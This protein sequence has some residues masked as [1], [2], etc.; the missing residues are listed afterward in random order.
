V[1]PH[2]ERLTTALADRYRIERELGQ[3]GMA[4]DRDHL[5]TRL[6]LGR[7]QQAVAAARQSGI[8]DDSIAIAAT[9]YFGTPRD[10]ALGAAQRQARLALSPAATTVAGRRA[11]YTAACQMGQWTLVH[12]P[13]GSAVEFISVLRR[14][15]RTLDAV[16]APEA[17]PVCLAMLEAMQAVRDRRPDRVALVVQ[18]D[19]LLLTVPPGTSGVNTPPDAGS[20]RSTWLPPVCWSAW[21]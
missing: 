11:Q 3:G 15:T 8:W 9:L 5:W 14:G 20:R 10:A 17:N 7:P 4:T 6:E 16:G 12:E 2:P 21:A 1:T 13:G 19:S 18:L